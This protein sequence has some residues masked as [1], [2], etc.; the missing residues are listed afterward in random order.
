MTTLAAVARLSPSPVPWTRL[1]WVVWRRYRTTLA[2]T[3]AVLTV[4]AGYLVINAERMR[5]AYTSAVNCRPVDSAACRFKYENFHGTYGTSGLI[6]VVLLLMPGLVGAFAGAG[7]LAREMESGTFRY[8]WTQGVGR[9]RWTVALLVPGAVGVGVIMAAFGAV[10]SWCDQPLF[11]SGITPRLHNTIFPT[12]G[13]AA[14]GWAVI[15]FA[16]GALGG[17]L[18]RR[19]VP[20][21]VSA[22]AVWFG[23]ALL[24]AQVL[25]PNYRSPLTTTSLQ[26]P[27]SDFELGQW[28]TK[29]GVRVSDAQLNAALGAINGQVVGGGNSV[30]VGPTNGGDP[31]QYLLQHGYLQVTSY[32]PDSRFWTF[33]WIEFSWL[34]ALALIL[35]TITFWLIR[36]R[37]A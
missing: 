10:I 21:L 19:V 25:R 16:L 5:S 26:L 7:V 12:I 27:S 20:A 37:P 13:A 6:G 32:Q 18:W 1:G 35:L 14:S 24:T 11:Q 22:F 28:W 31:V 3:L 17:L 2:A 29:N 23:M 33:Q 9:M 36:R 34:T 30:K 8:A 4:L 15:G